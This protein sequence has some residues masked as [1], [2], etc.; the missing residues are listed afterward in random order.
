[1]NEER[2][3]RIETLYHQAMERPVSER[4]GFLEEACAGHMSVLQEVETL[5]LQEAKAASFLATP[6]MHVAAKLL[7][8]DNSPGDVAGTIGLYKI[9]SRLGGGGMGEVSHM[10]AARW[11][12]VKEVFSALITRQP[13]GNGDLLAACGDDA[14]LADLVRPLIEEHRRLEA[15]AGKHVSITAAAPELPCVFAGRFRVLARLGGGSFGEVYRVIDE[16]GGHDGELALKVLRSSDPTAIQHFKREF[17][18]LADSYHR[19]IVRFHELI[20]WE[21][22]WMFTMELVDGV[23]LLQYLAGRRSNHEAALRSCMRQLAEGLSALHRRHLLHRDVKPSNILVTE[24]GRLVLLD[25]GLV[26]V[27]GPNHE[28]LATFAG[29]PDYM[30]PEQAAGAPVGAAS[31]WYAVGVLLYQC[32]AGR[33]PFEGGFLEVL[34]RKQLERPM[35]PAEMVRDVPAQLDAL[36]MKL[37]ERDPLSRASYGD[38]VEWTKAE[39]C[40]L[41]PE[42]ASVLFVGRKDSLR[43]LEEALATA[44]EQPV[45]AHVYGPSGI[46]KTALLREF[47]TGLAQDASVLVFSGRC[48]EGETLPYQA[49]DDLIDHIGEHFRRLP[50]DRVERL[51]PR[52]FAF[53]VKMFPVLTPFLC[54][55]TRPVDRLNSAELRTRALGALR[56]LLGRLAERHR[57]VLVIDDLQWGDLDGCAALND[58]LTSPDSPPVLVVLAYRSEDLDIAEPLAMLR[59]KPEQASGRTAFFIELGH[60]DDS[61]ACELAC[62]LLCQPLRSDTLKRITGHASGNPFLVQE[63]V[64]W[65]NV[66]G[67][68]PVLNQPFSL[69]DVVRS[70]MDLVTPESRRCLELLAVAGQPTEL[71][72]LHSAS[73]IADVRFVRDELVYNRLLRSRIL[74]GRE[75]VEI[76]HDRIRATIVS[77]ID[78]ATRV[79]CHRQLARALESLGGHDPERI[80]AHYEQAGD[81]QSCGRYALIAARRACDVLA[82]NEAARFF[83]MAIQ[84][85]TLDPSERRRVHHECADALANAGHGPRAAEYYSAAC[86]GASIDEQL[87]WNLKAAEQWLYSGHVDRGL[88]IFALVLEGVGIRSPKTRRIPF[89]LLLARARLRL[90]GLGWRERAV[91]DLQRGVLLKIDTCASVATGLAMVNVT[92]GAALQTTSLLLALNAGEPNRIA[93]AFAM[94]AGYRSTRGV[95]SKGDAEY[96]LNRA[97]ELSSRT[98]EPRAVA[99]TSIMAAGC[100]WNF[101]AWDECCRHARFAREALKDRYERLTWERDTAVI[102]EVDALRWMGRWSLMQEILPALIEDA[103]SRG[104]LYAESLLQMHGGSCAAL[105][106]D[107]PECART[108]LRIVERWSNT[109]YHLEHLVETHNQ[110]EIALYRG[111]GDEALSIVTSRWPAMRQSLLMRIEALSIQMRSLRARAAL[112]AAAQQASGP[113]RRQLLHVARAESRRLMRESAPWGA[114]L[115]E[116]AAGVTLQLDG[117][118]DSA[119]TLFGRAEQSFERAGMLMH[120]LVARRCKGVLT[121]GDEGRALV[122]SADSGLL[123]EAVLI[124]ARLALVVAPTLTSGS[125]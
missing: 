93:R 62:S 61:E 80:A 47:K 69:V 70:R 109:G 24:S 22:R 113:R 43:R 58:L 77:E 102:F 59:G 112:L 66:R 30:S 3:Q 20:A 29:T 46:G 12:R 6:A 48:Y 117:D 75:Q 37:L 63:I 122:A 91:S 42:T 105:A 72:I 33:L 65:I 55:D 41:P 110:V 118:D 89:D 53:L 18:S 106:K 51:L 64:R 13:S 101:G 74:H 23:N 60:L 81:G 15:E 71:P 16:A 40:A 35:P 45:I 52:N 8:D 96:L 4:R 50:R 124:P 120:E 99:L 76:Y 100:A 19:N 107:D 32:L 78:E 26:R 88:T 86:E 57:V 119:I 1:M 11:Q 84:T 95:R 68:G 10:D 115:G 125:A 5:L 44:Q 79:S 92:G 38:V 114:A 85:G 97:R 123:A 82:F 98:G 121:G 2:W 83:E 9:L 7:S 104:D 27:F 94:E 34:R 116:L 21:D 56:E 108:G 54:N 111:C 36:C 28:S 90:R 14:E 87:E 49:L 103:R 31:D 25:F 39:E 73:G 67:A 17:R